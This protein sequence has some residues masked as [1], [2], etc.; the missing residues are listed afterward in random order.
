MS[1]VSAYPLAVSCHGRDDLQCIHFSTAPDFLVTRVNIM[2]DMMFLTFHAYH[3]IFVIALIG[4]RCLYPVDLTA[5][6]RFMLQGTS[7]HAIDSIF[8][9]HGALCDASLNLGSPLSLRPIT[10]GFRPP[11]F[12]TILRSLNQAR[13]SC[14]INRRGLR[15]YFWIYYKIT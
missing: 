2:S 10:I 6:L 11:I 1:P 14:R 3:A 7:I 12:M 13:Y 8:Y 15:P 5:R 9:P 4:Y